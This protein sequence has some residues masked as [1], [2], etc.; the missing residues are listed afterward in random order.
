ML[1]YKNLKYLNQD[2][3]KDILYSET[4][5]QMFFCNN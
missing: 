1:I 5:T 4:I 3:T 2:L